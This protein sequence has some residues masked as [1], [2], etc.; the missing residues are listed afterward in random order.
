[1]K[2]FFKLFF[3]A[4]FLLVSLGIAS[5]SANDIYIG[6][7]GS[8]GANGSSCS[9]AYPASFFNTS[10]NWGSADTQIGP[11]TTAH[12]CGTIG[13]SLTAQGNGVSGNLVTILFEAGAK[14]SQPV[15]NAMTGCL[16]LNG[17]NYVTVDGGSNGVIEN[18]A[19]GTGR[20]NHGGS[21]GISAD[22]CDNCEI[23]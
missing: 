12:L 15:C 4:L 5:A 14:L 17:R 23:R 9:N 18:T 21:R 8:G 16:S 1:M 11:G 10:S 22:G 7:S 13:T 2:G 3:L 6:Q 20:A 19:N